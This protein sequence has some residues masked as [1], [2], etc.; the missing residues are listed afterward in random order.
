M[1]YLA[2]DI[3]KQTV[4]TKDNVSLMIDGVLFIRVEDAY[5]ASYKI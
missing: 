5:K 3:D 1:H 2:I 4:I